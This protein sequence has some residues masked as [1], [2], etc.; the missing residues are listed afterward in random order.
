MGRMH[1]Y[2]GQLYMS[3]SGSGTA[4]PVA[5]VKSWNFSQP[6]DFAD[7]A[8][9]GDRHKSYRAG[10]TDPSIK[11]GLLF[12]DT[13]LATLKTAEQSSDGVKFYLYMSRD[14]PGKYI[15]GTGILDLTPI[16]GDVKGILSVDA[17]LK[18]YTDDWDY[19]AS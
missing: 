17:M 2:R 18:P 12:D 3:T 16:A 10:L 14:V 6:K 7:A 8:A 4:S 13:Q 15:Y 1:G 9:M 11:L 19:K 5:N